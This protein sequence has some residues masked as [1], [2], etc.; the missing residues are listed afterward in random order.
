[1]E[2]KKATET[3]TETIATQEK[4]VDDSEAK[5]AALE[6]EKAELIKKASDGENYR[7]A[8]LK[9]K[10]KARDDEETDDERM[11]RIARKAITD[12]RLS[13]INREKD[14]IIAKAL[15]ENRELKLAQANKTD[16]PV[17]TTTHQEGKTVRDTLITPDQESYFKNTLHWSDKEIERYKK[18][19]NRY[20]K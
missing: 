4:V 16:I 14:A 20:G 5:I 15:K 9:E 2:E 3:S 1:M 11:E 18:N 17:S 10:S 6:A 7:V 8:Y 19:L 12:S 13:E